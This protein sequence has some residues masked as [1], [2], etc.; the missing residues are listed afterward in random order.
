LGNS[1]EFAS[2]HYRAAA[3]YNCVENRLDFPS[4]DLCERIM[5][6]LI[7]FPLEVPIFVMEHLQNACFIFYYWD[8]TR[9]GV[10]FPCLSYDQNSRAVFSQQKR[11]YP[12]KPKTNPSSRRLSMILTCQT[13]RERIF[14][15][16]K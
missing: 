9:S 13:C 14:F 1:G 12:H 2:G 5:S 4:T 16:E 6:A 15:L 3:P 11:K 8:K 10:F 7:L